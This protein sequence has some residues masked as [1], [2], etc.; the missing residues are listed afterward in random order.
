M[1]CFCWLASV[2]LHL[3]LLSLAHATQL[4]HTYSGRNV[5]APLPECLEAMLREHVL[6]FAKHDTLREVA[7]MHLWPSSSFG[8]ELSAA[9][10]GLRVAGCGLRAVG[11]GLWTA[12]CARR[13]RLRLRLRPRQVDVDVHKDAPWSGNVT[14]G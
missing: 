11:C 14:R 7:D 1:T 3:F 8:C 4:E 10:C 6:K 5:K 9:G 12:G 13:L 2:L